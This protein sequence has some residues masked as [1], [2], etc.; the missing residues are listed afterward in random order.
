MR[1]R[2]YLCG[3]ASFPT[4]PTP[5]QS[6]TTMALGQSTRGGP[7]PFGNRYR[8]GNGRARPPRARIPPSSAA[9]GGS[10]KAASPWTAHAP[11]GGSHSQKCAAGPGSGEG[12]RVRAD[13]I[14][15]RRPRTGTHV[16]SPQRAQQPRTT[17]GDGEK[18]NI[19]SIIQRLLEGECERRAACPRRSG[20]GRF[21]RRL[22]GRLCAGLWGGGEL[23]PLY[24]TEG[25]GST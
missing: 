22:P 7:S 24:Y 6:A 14:S 12:P 16:T 8:N 25:E 19:D 13:V 17:M 11:Y 4:S 10:G 3:I 15:R 2:V 23:L 18:L 5:R 1:C 9:N 20:P 21:Y